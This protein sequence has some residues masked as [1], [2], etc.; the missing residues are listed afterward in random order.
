MNRLPLDMKDYKATNM[1]TSQKIGFS[2]VMI[3]LLLALLSWMDNR[4][5]EHQA[6]MMA[7]QCIDSRG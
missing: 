6:E 3:T 4:D 1:A 2:I 7:Q 5:R